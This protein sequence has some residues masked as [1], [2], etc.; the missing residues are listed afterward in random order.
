MTDITIEPVGEIE[1]Q[2]LMDWLDQAAMHNIDVRKVESIERAYENHVDF[3]LEQADEDR[4]DPTRFVAMIGFAL[5]QWLT[6]NSVLEWR[7]ITDDQGRDIGLALPDNSS[8]MFPSDFVADAWN[9]V[10][11]QW[12]SEWAHEL[13]AQLEALR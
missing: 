5:G 13:R 9:E 12:L 1:Q 6:L 2:V 10:R 7:V 11:R 3:V 8:F 4:T